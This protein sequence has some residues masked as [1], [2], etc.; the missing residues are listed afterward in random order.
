MSASQETSYPAHLPERSGAQELIGYTIDLSDPQGKA[1]V[2]LDVEAKH[3]NRNGTLQGGIHAMMLDA[4]AGFSAS[5][6]L[7]GQDPVVTPVVTLSLTANF[8]S[9]APLGA[10]IATG[11][12]VGGGRKVVYANAEIRDDQGRLLSQGNG[13]FK[14]IAI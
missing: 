6:Y 5:R 3:L 8:L 4:A 10:V 9:P 14:R 11:H 12:V 2:R 1:V 13:V 7:A